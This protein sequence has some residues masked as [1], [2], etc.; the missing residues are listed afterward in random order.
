MTTLLDEIAAILERNNIANT[1]V[2]ADRIVRAAQALTH[3]NHAA[4][5]R[6][7]AERRVTGVPLAYVTGHEIF[8]GIDLIAVEGAL[9]PREVTELLGNAALDVLRS[10]SSTAPRVI[11]MC[12]GSG[13]LACAIA[14]YQPNAHVW[15]SDLTDDCI[16]VSRRNVEHIGVADRVNVI[17]GDLFAGLAGLDLEGTVDVVVCGPPFISQ[18]KLATTSAWLLQHEPREA[19]DGGP[20]GITIHQR[21]IKEVLPFLRPG[22]SLVLEIGLGQERQVKMLFDR[23][24]AY[25]DIQSVVNLAGEVLVMSGRRRV[26]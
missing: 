26:T 23:V 6:A 11:D 14:H 16:A 2:E 8:M 12:C 3:D 22:G 17:Q 21:V 4:A 24:N 18:S 25:E 19:F 1:L 10:S 13:N 15:A 7:M 5:A 9:V 20:Y